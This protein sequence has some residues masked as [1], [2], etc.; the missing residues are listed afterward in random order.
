MVRKGWISPGAAEEI[1]VEVS[2][3]LETAVEYALAAPFPEPATAL[4]DV[5]C[6]TQTSPAGG[7]RP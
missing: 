2:Q 3:Q 1:E 5:Y 7:G 6:S 4:E